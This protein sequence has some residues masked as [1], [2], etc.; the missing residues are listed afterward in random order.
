MAGL[1]IEL[2]VSEIDKLA[3]KFPGFERIIFR[4]MDAAM[5]GSLEVFKTEVVGRTPVNLGSLRQSIQSVTRG[6]P[7]RFQGEVS[8]PLIYGAPVERGR[9]PGRMPPVNVIEL[10]VQH[11]LGLQGNEARSAAFLIARAIGRRGTKGAFM[12]QKG[13]EAGKP[14]VEKLWRNVASRAVKRIEASI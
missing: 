12:F 1:E 13:F 2:D 7:P 6:S 10:W 14:R 11:K 4:E 3:R 5:R 9:K 8:T